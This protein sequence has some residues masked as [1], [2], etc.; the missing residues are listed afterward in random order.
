MNQDKG[1]ILAGLVL[2]RDQV[3]EDLKTVLVGGEDDKRANADLARINELMVEV[4]DA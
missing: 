4:R 3:I 1:L 2:L